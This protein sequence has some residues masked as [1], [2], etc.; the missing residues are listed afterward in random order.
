MNYFLTCLSAVYAIK[1]AMFFE[2]C[3]VLLVAFRSSAKFY[4][5]S[6]HGYRA[7]CDY[8]TYVL[9]PRM[10]TMSFVYN[11][12]YFLLISFLQFFYIVACEEKGIIERNK[13]GFSGRRG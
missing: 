4:D 8:L 7:S 2:G 6:Q 9:P 12:F 1:T 13:H 3:G 11:L 10:T 5:G